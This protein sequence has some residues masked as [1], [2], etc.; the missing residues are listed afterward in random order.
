MMNIQNFKRLLHL[1]LLGIPVKEPYGKIFD[2][3]LDFF[4]PVK[5]VKIIDWDNDEN[6]C[7]IGKKDKVVYTIYFHKDNKNYTLAVNKGFVKLMNSVFPKTDDIDVGDDMKR[8]MARVVLKQ[9]GVVF[10]DIWISDI[11][12]VI[13]ESYYG[14]IAK[15]YKTGNFVLLEH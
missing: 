2:T 10:D 5:I 14:D 15:K 12:D 7:C 13:T 1:H 3:A 6:T 11:G 9:K 4:E 8:E